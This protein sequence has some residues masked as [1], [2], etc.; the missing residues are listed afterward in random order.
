MPPIPAEYRDMV[1]PVPPASGSA[2]SPNVGG[3]PVHSPRPGAGAE[4]IEITE[5]ADG[6]IVWQV[7]RDLNRRGSTISS[8]GGRDST[9]YGGDRMSFFPRGLRSPRIR[10]STI[11]GDTDSVLEFTSHL[12]EASPRMSQVSGGVARPLSGSSTTRDDLRTFLASHRTA[13]QAAPETDDSYNLPLSDLP[14]QQS[15]S[16][17]YEEDDDEAATHVIWTTD[18]DISAMLESLSRG[19]DSA[20]FEIKVDGNTPIP[21]SSLTAGPNTSGAHWEEEHARRLRVEE[22]IYN[23]LAA[24]ESAPTGGNAQSPSNHTTGPL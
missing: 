15:S 3:A 2:L 19:T 14:P 17:P 13:A 11:S 12:S 21:S 4:G 7:I 5:R 23:L 9:I 1:R 24:R 16:D 20:K 22:D 18:D 8:V 10:D 6:S